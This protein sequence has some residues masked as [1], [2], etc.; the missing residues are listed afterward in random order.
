MMWSLTEKTLI[1]SYRLFSEG[2]TGREHGRHSLG[3]K[4]KKQPQERMPKIGDG[5][6]ASLQ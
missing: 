2:P 3:E 1:L 4:K 5:G 6:D